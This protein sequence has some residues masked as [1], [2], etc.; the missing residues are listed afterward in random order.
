MW[1]EEGRCHVQQCG[2]GVPRGGERMAVASGQ[3][4]AV[5]P[6]CQGAKGENFKLD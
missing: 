4:K 5:T 3:K 1:A 2:G 6:R